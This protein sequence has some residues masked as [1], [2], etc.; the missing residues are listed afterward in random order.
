MAKLSAQSQRVQQKRLMK[1]LKAVAKCDSVERGVFSVELADEN[2]F[3]VCCLEARQTRRGD[4]QRQRQKARGRGR[5]RAAEVESET[6]RRGGSEE[7]HRARHSTPPS[8]VS[9][10][11]PPSSPA[12]PPT[13][14]ATL[15]AAAPVC[16]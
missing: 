3:E 4:R 11:L 14:A 6:L 15:A 5:K 10:A 2:L 13:F 16:S 9:F 7:G 12:P 1:E 8:C